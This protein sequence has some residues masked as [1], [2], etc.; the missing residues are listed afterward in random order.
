MLLWFAIGQEMNATTI[1]QVIVSVWILQDLVGIVV[2]LFHG[3][4]M[5]HGLSLVQARNLEP[6]NCVQQTVERFW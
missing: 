3:N 2:N 1:P 6:S 4:T 5:V